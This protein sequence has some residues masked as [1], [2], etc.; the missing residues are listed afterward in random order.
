MRAHPVQVRRRVRHRD[1]PLDDRR[2]RRRYYLPLASAHLHLLERVRRLRARDQRDGCKDLVVVHVVGARVAHLVGPLADLAH[3]RTQLRLGVVARVV[4][5]RDEGKGI[6]HTMQ[7]HL[8]Q[9]ALFLCHL[10]LAL[11][12]AQAQRL[13]DEL[14]R[15]HG[16]LAIVGQFHFD[17]SE[18][19][20]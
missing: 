8:E 20:A 19:V 13:G 6:L 17:A 10:S 18:A 2:A 14:A 5:H 1:L 11:L 3:E 9:R 7:G 12:D 4:W 15:A 16:V